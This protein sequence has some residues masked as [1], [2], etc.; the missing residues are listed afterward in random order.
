MHLRRGSLHSNSFLARSSIDAGGVY[1]N[2][3]RAQIELVGVE[4]ARG[5]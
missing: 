3:R 5:G 1:V 4:P 2:D